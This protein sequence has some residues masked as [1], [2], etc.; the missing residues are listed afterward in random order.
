MIGVL[1]FLA[2]IFFFLVLVIY[3][4][5]AMGDGI[6]GVAEQRGGMN[7]ALWG[8]GIFIVLCWGGVI[9]LLDFIKRKMS[10]TS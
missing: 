7:V 9:S 3:I 8:I 2:H 10:K 4:F 1:K 5:T 6:Q